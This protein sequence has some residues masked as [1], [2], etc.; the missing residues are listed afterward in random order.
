MEDVSK[1]NS[2]EISNLISDKEKELGIATNAFYNVEQEK[3]LLQRQILELRI[4]L[5]D[6]EVIL[7]KASQNL[8]KM[9]LELKALRSFFWNARESGI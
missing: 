5:K 7:S 9:Q 3:L 1:L 6:L 4:K 2:A 8:K